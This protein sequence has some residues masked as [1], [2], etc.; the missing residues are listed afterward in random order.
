MKLLKA[1]LTICALC[2]LSN[3]LLLRNICSRS[4][5]FTKKDIHRRRSTTK[6][7]F[8]GIVEVRIYL[9]IHSGIPNFTIAHYILQPVHYPFLIFE[10]IGFRNSRT[11]DYQ[12]FSAAMGWLCWG[13]CRADYHIICC[14]SRCLHRMQHCR[15]WC[16]SHC[17]S[18]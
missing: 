16:M 17:N 11:V 6:M 13:G 9:L 18:T 10:S 1:F 5:A 2:G 12:S 4:K 8:S 3:A 7:M 14:S 15:E